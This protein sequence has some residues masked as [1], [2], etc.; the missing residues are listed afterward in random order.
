MRRNRNLHQLIFNMATYRYHFRASKRPGS[1]EGKLFIR[2]IHHRQYKDIATQ[3]KIHSPE[4]DPVG[5]RII[6]HH[7]SPER[8]NHLAL[9]EGSLRNDLSTLRVIEKQLAGKGTYSAR[10]VVDAFKGTSLDTYNLMAYCDVVSKRLIALGQERTARAYRSAVRSLAIFRGAKS[11]SLDDITQSL[12][13]EYESYLKKSGLEMNTIS[14][15]L[16]N[17]RALYYR[18]VADRL[19]ELRAENPFIGVYTGV[20]ISKKRALNTDELKAF[21]NTGKKLRAEA[22]NS[23]SRKQHNIAVLWD[24]LLYFN[25]CTEGRGIS[26]VDMAFLK[27]SDMREETFTYRRKK[28]GRPLEVF[29]TPY[30][31]R[32]IDHF[33]AQTEGSPYVFPVVDPR[34]GNERRQY[35]S[36]LRSQN[37]RLGVLSR[38]AGIPKKVTTHVSRHTWATTARNEGV[39]IPVISEMLGHSDIRV[40]YRYLDSIENDLMIRVTKRVSK[41]LGKAA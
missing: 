6:Y 14:F 16:R 15:Y 41:A 22:T 26:W 9:I 7:D 38:M 40:T 23:G 33:A 27:K 8:N 3:H 36:G 29:I 1:D 25:F 39:E 31:R 13:R 10:D 2:V 34:R 28:T 18:A 37:D 21:R 17:L 5:G 12:M 11:L 32:I 30:M 35:E 24:T 20:C 4:W 19:I